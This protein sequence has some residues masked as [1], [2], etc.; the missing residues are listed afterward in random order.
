M[1][2]RSAFGKSRLHTSDSF[3]LAD[4]LVHP[5]RVGEIIKGNPSYVR[6]ECPNLPGIPFYGPAA[7]LPISSVLRG[8]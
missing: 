8:S 7:P 4:A 3:R 6:I 1:G 2:L 5:D